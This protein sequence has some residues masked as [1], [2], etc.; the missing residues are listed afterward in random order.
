MLLIDENVRRGGNLDIR[1]KHGPGTFNSGWTCLHIASAYGIEPIVERLVKEGATVETRNSF[2]YSPLLESCHRGFAS[3]AKILI[4]GGASLSF[5]P[6]EE[7]WGKSPFVTSPCQSPLAEASRSGF[8][9]IVEL[10]LDAGADINQCNFLGWTPLHEACFYNR[11]DVAKTLMLRGANA[12]LRTVRGALPYHF[13]SHPA[14]KELIAEIGGDAAVPA[15]DD[16]INM[17]Q[18]LAEI[19]I[20]NRVSIMANGT[21][22]HPP[23]TMPSHLVSAVDSNEGE[24]KDADEDEADAQNDETF[25]QQ[26]QAEETAPLINTGGLLGDLPSLE[27]KSPDKPRREAKGHEE[28]KK[29]QKKRPDLAPPDMPKEFL[30]ELTR[31]PMTDPVKTIYGNVF[32]KSTLLSWFTNQGRVCP[33]SGECFLD[34]CAR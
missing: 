30:C 24:G 26:A 34:R 18:V 6:S 23:A 9:Q 3:I 27:K 32:E 4:D 1:T 13:A 15:E 21:C 7:D 33:V 29:A 12:T 31:K 17:L 5:I 14:I 22:I 25:S 11:L 28:K 2:G 8:L 16:E 20:P 10:L 19:S